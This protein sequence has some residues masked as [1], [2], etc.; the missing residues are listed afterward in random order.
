MDYLKERGRFHNKP[1]E[2]VVNETL[3]QA[4]EAGKAPEP[5]GAGDKKKDWMMGMTE[6]YLGFHPLPQGE[7]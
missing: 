3:R 5:D 2:K 4:M 7:G 6:L 1:L